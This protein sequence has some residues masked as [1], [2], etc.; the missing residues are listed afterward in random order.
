MK[1]DYAIIS[2]DSNPMYL[3]FW[4]IVSKLWKQK[5][6][7]EPILIYIDEEKD[8]EISEEYGT[9]L[10]LTP[11][12]NIPLYIQTL[13]SRYWLPSL[14]PNK[15]CI[16]SDIDMLPLSKEYFID[17]IKEIPDDKYVHLNPCVVIKVHSVNSFPVLTEIPL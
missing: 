10:R 6:N 4:P 2:S 3:D 16:I 14:Y 17:K 7:I 5:F 8:K 1:I 13:W 11:L 9:V 12:E 15:T